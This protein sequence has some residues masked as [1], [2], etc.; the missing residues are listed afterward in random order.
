MRAKLT[1]N[2]AYKTPFLLSWLLSASLVLGSLIFYFRIQPQIP[3]FYSLA[4]PSQH[5]MSKEWLFLFPVFSLLINMIHWLIAQ[6]NKNPTELLA[7]LFAWMSF[8]I[9][10]LLFVAWL[11]ILLIIT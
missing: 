1:L 5:L 4:R 2:P 10:F 6:T 8:G 7:K 3:I 9:Q 11:R